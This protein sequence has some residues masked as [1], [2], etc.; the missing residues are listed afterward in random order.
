MHFKSI[1]VSSVIQ[2]RE[3]KITGIVTAKLLETYLAGIL[4]S[5][6]QKFP[7]VVISQKN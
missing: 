4:H 7:L 3:T 2:L 1:S 5:K 6:V